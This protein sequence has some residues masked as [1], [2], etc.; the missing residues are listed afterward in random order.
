[1]EYGA[2]IGLSYEKIFGADKNLGLVFPFSIVLE[3]NNGPGYKYN[4]G[5]D[6]NA[7]FYFMPGLKVYPFGQRRLAYAVGPTFMIGYGMTRN[8]TWYT[9]FQVEGA[10][11][12]WLRM[13]G[14]I[15]N[16]L[17]YQVTRSFNLGLEMG[18]GVRYLD[19]QTYTEPGQRD[20][21][22]LNN[23]VKPTGRFALTLGLR[24]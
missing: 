13:G 4:T 18:L 19:R 21:L 10:K 1:M 17:N 2:G 16:Y 3:G 22:H 7:S 20:P 5:S 14:M 23:S 12:S 24:F 6:V 11:M 9:G 8:T 15:T